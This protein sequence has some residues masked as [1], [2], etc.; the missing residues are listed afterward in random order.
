MKKENSMISAS[1]WT[2]LIL[3]VGRQHVLGSEGNG[4]GSVQNDQQAPTDQPKETPD[5]TLP[6]FLTPY[7]ELC[8]YETAKNLSKVDFFQYIANV[9]AYSGLITVNKTY[10]SSLF[11]LF[12]IAEGNS[13]DAPILLW[14]Q[15]GPGLSSLF[16]QFLENGPIAFDGKPNI[17]IR[18]NTLQKN[19]S[20]LYLDVPVGT[21]FSFT[22]NQA[23]YSTSLEDITKDVLEFLRQFFQLFYEYQNRDF[24]LAGESYGARYSVAVA[25]ELL[26]TNSQL[27]LNLKGIVGGNGFL[28]PVLETADSSQFLYQVSMLDEKGRDEFA[29]R[30]QI[31]RNMSKTENAS[32]VPLILLSTIFADPTGARRS[33]FQNLTYY[34]D[35]AS[36]LYTQR[37]LHMLM[38]FGFLNQSVDFRRQIHV[39]DNATF[40][41]GDEVLIKTFAADWLRDIRNMT[42]RVLN[43]TSV[44]L[45]TGQID[46]LFPSV[47]QRNYYATLEW[48]KAGEYRNTSR[49]LWRPTTWKD[50]MGYAGYIKKVSGFSEAVLLGMSHYGAAEKPDEV[51]YLIMEFIESSRQKAEHLSTPNS[52]DESSSIAAK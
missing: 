45:Y 33:V 4:G 34:S 47:L 27:P 28:G 46:A 48:A 13:S 24:Y 44:L 49:S 12:L 25:N 15:G 7:I 51:Y 35:H 31:M 43:E 17:S 50:P 9:S 18:S 2:L 19:M 39:G 40:K 30:F 23:G 32:Y 3:A 20:V 52:R 22:Q 41:Y 38:C 8:D 26:S 16:G 37:P 5:G 11:F 36:P 1:A 29:L 42:Q 10:N 21:G 6:L 14:T